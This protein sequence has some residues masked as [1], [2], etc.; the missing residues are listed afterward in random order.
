MVSLQLI[1]FLGQKMKIK[2]S[3]LKIETTKGTGKGGQRK[4]KV[5]TAVRMTHI[6][7]GISVFIDGRNQANNKRR[8]KRALQ[9]KLD[10]LEEEEK[11]RKKKEERDRK[12]KEPGYIR[13]YNF[14]RGTVK[15]KRC[16]KEFPLDKILK[17]G[18]LDL[19]YKEIK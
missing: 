3:D 15:D 8:A 5:E 12:I 14:K 10:T 2:K 16:K 13:T 19:I 18:K 11:Q 9:E 17:E 7:T 6:P 4:N 1:Q